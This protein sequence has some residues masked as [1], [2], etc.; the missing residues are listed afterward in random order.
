MEPSLKICLD[1]AGHVGCRVEASAGLLCFTR[2][3]LLL[4]PLRSGELN[5]KVSNRDPAPLS[6]HV[7]R[8]AMGTEDTT[9]WHLAMGTEDT[10]DWHL[11]MGT[12]DTADS[13]LAMGTGG[14]N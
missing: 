13:H 5:A 1:M 7:S 4:I 9:D 6:E 11:A 12:E 8:H 10:T 2:Y 3:H 14:Y